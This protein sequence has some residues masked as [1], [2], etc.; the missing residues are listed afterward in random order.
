M[1][2]KPLLAKHPNHKTPSLLALSLAFRSEPHQNKRW[3]G[4]CEVVK[5]PTLKTPAP[6]S[7]LGG[8]KCSNTRTVEQLAADFCSPNCRVADCLVSKGYHRK[9]QVRKKRLQPAGLHLVQQGKY[10]LVSS[11]KRLGRN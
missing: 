10:R 4:R 9:P 7:L 3:P 8:G 6:F 11:S 5:E 1:P 2:S